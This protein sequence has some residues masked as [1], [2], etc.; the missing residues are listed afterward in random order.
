[1]SKRCEWYFCVEEQEHH[2][3]GNALDFKNVNRINKNLGAYEKIASL[4]KITDQLC[5]R[6]QVL[7]S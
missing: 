1:M 4:M 5:S 7:Q 3:F 2:K 6:G